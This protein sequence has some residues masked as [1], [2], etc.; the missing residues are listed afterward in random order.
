MTIFVSKGILHLTADKQF[1]YRVSCLLATL[2]DC[3]DLF[4]NKQLI[5]LL[6]TPL[7][8][9]CLKDKHFYRYSLGHVHLCT[10]N[11]CICTVPQISNLKF[12]V[13]ARRG[14]AKRESAPSLFNSTRIFYAILTRNGL[15]CILGCCCCLCQIQL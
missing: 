2:S 8:K 15:F 6:A 7:H 10:G 3:A 12:N 11:N 14:E 5:L 13:G 1:C 4:V 9:K